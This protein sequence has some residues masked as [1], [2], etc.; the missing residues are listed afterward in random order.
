M[1]FRDGMDVDTRTCFDW[2]SCLTLLQPE[3]PGV[4][5]LASRPERS[6][7]L[8]SAA[9]LAGRTWNAFLLGNQWNIGSFF[10]MWFTKCRTVSDSLF[11]EVAQYLDLKWRSI[12]IGRNASAGQSI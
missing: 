2:M 6:M 4:C 9:S 10:L 8:T 7:G 5:D 11:L 1:Y 12:R 3:T